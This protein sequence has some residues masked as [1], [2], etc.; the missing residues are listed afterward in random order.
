MRKHS[1][2]SQR[3]GIVLLVALAMLGLFSVLIVSYVISTGQ[4]AAIT[5]LEQAQAREV[6]PVEASLE[7][8][9]AM[10]IHGS[11]DPHSAAYRHSLLEDL[12]GSDGV[13][14]RV[15]N[16]RGGS[17]GLSMPISQDGIDGRGFLLRAL[18]TGATPVSTLFKLPTSLAIWHNDGS[19]APEGA[20]DN[21]NAVPVGV[22]NLDDALSGRQMT[23]IEGPL[24]NMTFQIIRSFGADNTNDPTVAVDIETILAGSVV[25]DLNQAS[26]NEVDVNG[27][28]YDL[29]V[30]AAGSPGSLLYDLGDDGQ[31]G[32][33]SIDDDGDNVVDEPDEIGFPGSDD[34]GYRIVINGLPFN[35]LGSNPNGF[36][37]VSRN[38]PGQIVDAAADI[39]LQY[40]TRLLGAQSFGS[41][42]SG[43]TIPQQDEPWDVADFENVFLAWQPANHRSARDAAIY[44]GQTALDALVGSEIIPSFHRPAVINYL[45]NAPVVLPGEN[46]S[47]A[48]TFWQMDGTDPQDLIRLKTLARRIRRA[49]MRPL[50]FDHSS[51][52]LDGDGS[53][54]D[55]NPEF[56]GSNLAPVHWETISEA[57]S[58][59][60]MKVK[61]FSLGRWLANGPWDIDNDGDGLPDSVWVDLGLPSLQAATGE[62]IRPMIAPL[63]ED[64]DGRINLNQAGNYRQ[65]LTQR[66][67]SNN[68]NQYNSDA[69]Y[70]ATLSALGTYGRGGGIGPA[71]IDFSHLF[72]EGN[73]ISPGLFG[74]VF[75][76]QTSAA[77]TNFLFTRYGNLL[78]T[79]YGGSPLDYTT[80]PN[81]IPASALKFPGY[82]DN[83]MSVA[84]HRLKDQLARIPFPAREEF[85]S[86][87]ASVMGKSMDMSGLALARKDRN[88][89]EIIDNAVASYQN[90]LNEV[91]NQ[92][93]ENGMDDDTPFSALDLTFLIDQL[94]ASTSLDQLLRD[95]VQRN[96]SLRNLITTESRTVDV[97]ETS[98][99]HGV[100]G[101]FVG[102]L[103]NAPA[104]EIQLHL[105]RMLAPEFRK[106]GKMNLNRGLGNGRDDGDDPN[107]NLSNL[108]DET[109][110]TTAATSSVIIERQPEEAA[111]PQISSEFAIDSTIKADYAP[112]SVRQNSAEQLDFDGF[113]SDGDGFL[114]GGTDH[115]GD[116]IP[117]RIA[118]GQE[119]LA[120]HLYCLMFMLIEDTDNGG[121]F[122]PDFPYPD[123]FSSDKDV[124][125]RFVARR[126]AQWAA[127]AV[128]FRDTNSICTRLRYDP[129]PFNGFQLDEAARNTVWGMERPEIEISET[130]AFHDKRL[131][132]ELETPRD[133][134]NTSN[135]LDG[136]LASDEDDDPTDN[137]QPDTDMDQF[138]IPE[139]SAFV[140][141]RSL[142]TPVD[143]T[144]SQPRL[145]AELY[146]NNR[147]DLG[148]V[149]GKVIST[150]NGQVD[151]RSPVWRL[152][153]GEPVQRDTQKSI[154][155]LYD[156]ER[157]GGKLADQRSMPDQIDYLNV[158]APP[159]WS[160]P[161][162]AINS[163]EEAQKHGAEVR[164]SPSIANGSGE[165][166]TLTD[167]DFDPS[168]DATSNDSR[169]RL[170]RFVWFANLAPTDS[171]LLTNHPRS[172]MKPGNV[173]FNTSDPEDAND[174]TRPMNASPLLAPGQYA[175][176]A[177]RVSTTIGQTKE[178]I[179][180]Q[181]DY[182]PST[183]RLGL[184]YQANSPNPGV[185]RFNYHGLAD[186]D[187]DPETPRY[188]E[189]RPNNAY[190]DYHVN[191][192]VPIIAQSLPP[193]VVDNSPSWSSYRSS[194]PV[195]EQVRI[196]FNISAPLSGPNYYPAPTH[197]ISD[198][199][200]NGEGYPLVDG[201]RD[202]INGEGLHHDEPFDH[203]DLGQGGTSLLQN[204]WAGVG[205]HQEAVGVFLQRLA[206]P[207]THWHPIDNPYLTVDLAPMDLTTF[208]GEG[209]VTE[210]IDRNGDGDLDDIADNES[211]FDG[212]NFAPPVK[213]DS[214]RKIPDTKRDRAST[215]LVQRGQNE[216]TLA[217]YQRQVFTERSALSTSFSILRGFQELGSNSVFDYELGALW[218]DNHTPADS[219]IDS[220]YRYSAEWSPY[221][222]GM[223]L[224]PYRQTL[225]FVNREY[226]RPIGADDSNSNDTADVNQYGRGTPRGT[227]FLLPEWDDRD[228]Q[229]PL[230][231]IHI[232]AVSRTG[233]AN[234]FSPGTRL[235]DDAKR[236][237]P[238]RFEHLLGFEAKFSEPTNDDTPTTNNWRLGQPAPLANGED[239]LTGSRAPFELLFD[240]VSTGE[241]NYADN[242]W[243]EPG[244]V[245]FIVPSNAR[246]RVFNRVVEFLQPPYNYVPGLRTPG[247][248]NLN[249]TPDYIRKGGQF[250]FT[251]GDFLDFGESPENKDQVGAGGVNHA[252]VVS[253]AVSLTPNYVASPLFGNGSVYR[254][255]AWA[256][257]SYYDLD[258][259]LG[260]P[261]GLGDYDR[262]G[263][264]VDTRFGLGFKAFIES[265][266]GYDT[267]L[268][269]SDSTSTLKNPNLDWRYPTRFAGVFSTAQAAQIPSIQRFMLTKKN[270]T[271]Q[272]TGVRRRTHDMTVMRPHPDF[273]QR[274]FTP[275]QQSAFENPQDKIA[276]S[277]DVESD[278]TGSSVNLPGVNAAEQ[279]TELRM[280][281][282]NQGL[283]ERS[284]P[285]L[286]KDF[287]HR[288]HHPNARFENAAR[289]KNLTTHQSNVFIVRLTVGFFVEDPST[290]VVGQ[291]Y[292]NRDGEITRG[293]ATFIIDRSVPVGFVRGES[294]NVDQTILYSIL[295]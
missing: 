230:D 198:D 260:K 181:Y 165:F 194:T 183:Q 213:F 224:E 72:D 161:S 201:Y 189:D 263:Q 280:T 188:W 186:S 245:K 257:S 88:G 64:L 76:T 11:N 166:V 62:V 113:D 10:L 6:L 241:P 164:H 249:T 200:R 144:N 248:V 236:E 61:L 171:L 68:P 145:P 142:R 105:D 91:L 111:F 58:F 256:N 126:I 106:G 162:A 177:P 34:Y 122:V 234:T 287:Q 95:E 199:G 220:S 41:N 172:G 45:M 184:A 205:T 110:E 258:D 87:Q 285:E 271:N 261:T 174:Q 42:G 209:D 123:G 170:T 36:T 282:A 289:L 17:G 15:G 69:G 114:D 178:T 212:T 35:G 229:S 1:R 223:D 206:N 168:N 55:G 247:R 53:S 193:D 151:V 295:K 4:V 89:N 102:K 29:F 101:F 74:P 85:F 78:N 182:Y 38:G 30:T 31:P 148:R 90:D 262:Y 103:A 67:L 233:L 176:I 127:N 216:A 169:I 132:R 267:A 71:E 218:N 125:N 278:P 197:R 100:I 195:E 204:G 160:D 154:R 119:L 196:G 156:A 179:A 3:Q 217:S 191:S 264:I 49:T 292:E 96:A 70:L 268:Q 157:V 270:N 134:G 269:S 104:N 286:H 231:L 250:S 19:P 279:V 281:R 288:A 81:L 146:T 265:R 227:T 8:A 275:N 98:G 65:L 136:E 251:T 192:V 291:E 283:F 14:L 149:V 235:E 37:G 21:P 155:W 18:G 13:V 22:R 185:F 180:P 59:S 93:Y 272:M 277:L 255:I 118:D 140:E 2:P 215:Q 232:P 214:R 253:D 203:R 99:F 60:D 116:S 207:T 274:L 16:Q 210:Q 238:S 94:S 152:A 276:Y 222:P 92:P 237:L 5:D 23:F 84:Q 141:L 56:T 48:R 80:A 254:S 221:H 40:N 173:F 239:E 107:S 25:I 266:R 79:R 50:N 175:V 44:G 24:Q 46:P 133:P 190:Q 290:G 124:K 202:Y 219:G 159:D 28:A 83:S 51:G 252:P 112:L 108:K 115:D 138:R 225:G 117:E 187:N 242:R 97:P 52:D 121:V 86:T 12:Y 243:F 153:V 163:W 57:E 284:L 167:D 43:G 39:E 109:F 120:R 128:D 294:L 54:A 9:V 143:N 20:V 73:S 63:I 208:N 82:G 139:A 211:N 273:N 33:A 66:F 129:N 150:T 32:A 131:R 47:N 77:N 293:Q 7:D 226:G 240:F 246:A 158:N 259:L 75:H 27:V 130:L 147:L 244:S 135:D 137:I 26:S 228:L